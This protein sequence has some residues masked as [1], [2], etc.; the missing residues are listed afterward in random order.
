MAVTLCKFSGIDWLRPPSA[1][2]SAS[3]VSTLAK[4]AAGAG[5]NSLEVKVSLSHE[6]LLGLDIN[7]AMTLQYST[8]GKQVDA[9]LLLLLPLLPLLLLLGF[10]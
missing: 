10:A 3:H 8:P 2:D 5:T 6:R 1:L 4:P 7:T 9:D